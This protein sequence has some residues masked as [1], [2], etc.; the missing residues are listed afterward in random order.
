MSS[1]PDDA[2]TEAFKVAV[3]R[4]RECFLAEG[5]VRHEITKAY[6]VDRLTAIPEGTP[7]SY[8]LFRKVPV[9]FSKAPAYVKLLSSF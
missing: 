9:A 3:G 1:T 8:A 7:E 5:A 6:G 4:V 2:A